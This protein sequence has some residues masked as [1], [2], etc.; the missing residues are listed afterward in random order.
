M[1]TPKPASS[2]LPSFRLDGRLAVITGASQGIG[3]TFAQAFAQAGAELVLAGRNAERLDEVRRSI[4][5]A[6]GRAHTIAADLGTM[7]GIRSLERD[8]IENYR[9][10]RPAADSG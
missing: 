6:G 2:D 3:R 9:Q 1:T 8:V 5:G 4:E 7:D 10:E